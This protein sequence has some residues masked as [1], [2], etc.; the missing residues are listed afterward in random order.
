MEKAYEELCKERQQ[1]V[2]DAVALK[3][4]DRVP[5]W[6]QDASF[7]PAKYTGI[8]FR[9]A[10]YDSDKIFA[11]YKK[12]FADFEPDLCLNPGQDYV[13]VGLHAPISASKRHRG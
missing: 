12:T 5:I 1:R 6:F 9:E 4:P 3:I 11:A 7:F 13:H 10:M 2:Q 8:S